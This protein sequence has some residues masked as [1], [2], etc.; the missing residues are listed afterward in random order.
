MLNYTGCSNVLVLRPFLY[1]SSC[2]QHR[3]HRLLADMLLMYMIVSV[4]LYTIARLPDVRDVVVRAHSII[5]G[6]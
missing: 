1:F 3:Y 6:H 4:W 2:S 5:F